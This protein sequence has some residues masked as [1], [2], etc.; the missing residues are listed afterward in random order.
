[1]GL[2]PIKIIKNNWIFDFAL[3]KS[4]F[5]DFCYAP[6]KWTNVW[7]LSFN[8]NRKGAGS[9]SN[10]TVH[11]AQ[12]GCR[13]AGCWVRI[14]TRMYCR[15]STAIHPWRCPRTPWAC[16]RFDALGSVQI[17]R[18]DTIG[19]LLGA[20]K[21]V[22]TFVLFL[23]SEHGVFDVQLPWALVRQQRIIATTW[24]GLIQGVWVQ[25]QRYF[26]MI[27]NNSHLLGFNLFWGPPTVLVSVGSDWLVDD[28]VRRKRFCMIFFKIAEQA[29]SMAS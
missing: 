28:T 25:Y 22:F 7:V 6:L 19:T 17:Y 1:M 2:I 11:Q 26:K 27:L 14:Q 10:I 16:I 8:S 21:G 23:V 9:H 29:L 3:W 18:L 5:F 20:A 12:T 24:K 15:P 13:V 4:A